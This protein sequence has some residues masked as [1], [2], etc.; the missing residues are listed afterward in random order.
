M[1]FEF[2][3]MWKYIGRICGFF[4]GNLDSNVIINWFL[5]KIE[6]VV[7]IWKKMVSYKF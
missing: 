3:L 2:Y 6:R 5:K 1:L 7:V 4:M